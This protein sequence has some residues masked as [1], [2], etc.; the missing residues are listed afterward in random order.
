MKIKSKSTTTNVGLFFKFQMF[1]HNEVLEN[2]WKEV[3]FYQV[4]FNI[5]SRNV[6]R[7]NGIWRQGKATFD[8]KPGNLSGV[9]RASHIYRF[10]HQ[11][12]EFES[13]CL[14]NFCTLGGY[15]ASPLFYSWSQDTC[16]RGYK[17]LY[18]KRDSLYA[19][20]WLAWPSVYGHIKNFNFH[21]CNI[22]MSYHGSTQSSS[23]IVVSSQ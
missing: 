10:M 23:L 8:K 14:L 17:A 11:I 20:N 12:F 5:I 3:A 4:L 13:E 2:A 21:K 22:P 1:S 6:L 16:Q 19:L 7:P 15:F 9:N 18:E